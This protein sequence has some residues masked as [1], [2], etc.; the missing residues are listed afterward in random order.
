M[1]PRPRALALAAAS[2]IALGA[3]AR[4]GIHLGTAAGWL[5]RL[6][7]P[8]LL[9]PFLI[10]ALLAAPRR[11]AVAGAL[12]MLAAV[13]TYYALKVGVEH[14]A[15]RGYGIEMTALWGSIGLLA[16]AAFAALGAF[17]RTLPGAGRAVAVALV[18]GALAGEG[19]LML[20]TG[21]QLQVAH[22]A[23][24]IEL[25]VAGVLPLLFVRQARPTIA[26][27]VLS[28]ALALVSVHAV[29]SIRTFAF[30]AGWGAGYQ[31]P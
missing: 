21:P 31:L 20:R 15:T 10:G 25:V 6:G 1:T 2:G 14:R 17:A 18:S 7:V 8:W 9:V 4:L 13:A 28:V 3:A 12:A 30:H 22:E 11:A 27:I 24:L 23:A 5:L 19:L 26:A 29:S 16:G